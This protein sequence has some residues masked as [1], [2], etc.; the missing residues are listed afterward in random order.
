MM[1]AGRVMRVVIGSV[2]LGGFPACGRS[3][4][5]LD[6]V[7]RDQREIFFKLGRLERSVEQAATQPAAATAA[8]APKYP[9]KVYDIPVGGSPVKGPAKAPVTIVEF[10]DFQCPPCGEARALVKQILEAYPKD[11]KL[12]YKQF[13]L[14]S[15]HDNAMNAAKAAIAAGR[16][17]KFWEMHDFLYQH[18]SELGI[19]KLT[20]YAGRIGLDVPRWVKDFSSTAVQEQVVREMQDGRAADV[21]ATPTFFVSGSRVEDRS[22]DGFKSMIERSLRAQPGK[23][24]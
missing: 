3:V 6:Q 11:V 12:V 4:P 15:I 21:D 2:A 13:P 7:T 23:T 1:N 10:S 16:Q 22:F 20:E 24:G 19:D 5:D 17:E 14:T 8:P 18:Q 9:D